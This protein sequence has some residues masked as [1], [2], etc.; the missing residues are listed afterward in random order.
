MANRS[1]PAL[2]RVHY[3]I[4]WD[5]AQTL[6]GGATY[7]AAQDSTR[8]A[9]HFVRAAIVANHSRSGTLARSLRTDVSKRGTKEVRGLVRSSVKHADWFFYGTAQGGAGRIYPK[10]GPVLVLTEPSGKRGPRRRSVRG[11]RPKFP[12]LEQGVQVGLARVASGSRIP[13]GVRL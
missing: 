7:E 13:R 5:R 1:I 12:L 11:Q 4:P 8:A 6:P 3:S 2:V 10:N 9:F